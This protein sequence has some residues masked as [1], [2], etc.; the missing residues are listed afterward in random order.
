MCSNDMETGACPRRSLTLDELRWLEA[1]AW[2]EG[3]SSRPASPVAFDRDSSPPRWSSLSASAPE[4][5]SALFSHYELPLKGKSPMHLRCVLTPP[6]PSP[7]PPPPPYSTHVAS[8]PRARSNLRLKDDPLPHVQPT[9]IIPPD[10]GPRPAEWINRRPRPS[11]S[12][13]SAS[14]RSNFS[15]RS[16]IGRPGTRYAGPSTT[17]VN[18]YGTAKPEKEKSKGAPFWQVF[19]RPRSRTVPSEP[20]ALKTHSS[21][22]LTP[23]VA[24][25]LA[26]R[27]HSRT[28]SM[29]SLSSSV[30]SASSS[31]PETPSPLL[32]S[33][34]FEPHHRGVA[35]AAAPCLHH[36]NARTSSV[37]TKD[38]AATKASSV[39]ASSSIPPPSAMSS[40]K[41]VK[42]APAPTVHYASAGYWEVEARLCAKEEESFGI[43]LDDMDFD[44]AT[45]EHGALIASLRPPPS[46]KKEKERKEGALGFGRRKSTKSRSRSRSK[47]GDDRSL[48]RLVGLRR[49]GPPPRPSISG[50]YALGTAPVAIPRERDAPVSSASSFMSTGSGSSSLHSKSSL[51]SGKSSLRSR[52]VKGTVSSSAPLRRAPSMDSVKSGGARSLGSFTSTSG[53]VRGWLGRVIAP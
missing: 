22:S 48:R 18:T 41:S 14:Q 3:R 44:M 16:A 33:S 28:P 25:S 46:P 12:G 37:T 34:K 39:S 7:T 30:T 40:S 52:L 6:T 27:M 11:R 42:F 45:S 2:F 50:P 35:G 24:H 8:I 20:R 17:S 4:R 23:T 26:P 47:E 19:M 31:R 10:D 9:E 43:D 36:R 29:S 13:S 51:R 15:Q 21:Q 5:S 1:S 49:A 53:S 32:P 38:S